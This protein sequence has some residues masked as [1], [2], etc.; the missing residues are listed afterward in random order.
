M[1]EYSWIVRT[2]QRRLMNLAVAC[3]RF[4]APLIE[5]P[6]GDQRCTRQLLLAGLHDLKE[7]VLAPDLLDTERFQN[8]V[9]F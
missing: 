5:I 7:R 2:G 1:G 4:S 3:N 9:G 8:F 6:I